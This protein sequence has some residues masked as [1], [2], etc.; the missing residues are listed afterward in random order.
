MT[1][2][3]TSQG[4]SWVSEPRPDRY[5]V[6]DT[7]AKLEREPKR[8]EIGLCVYMIAAT[9][10]AIAFGTGALVLSEDR[11]RQAVSAHSGNGHLSQGDT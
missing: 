3:F 6:K 4:T 10:L 2:R 5:R 8:F 11:S 1:R 7:G 9:V